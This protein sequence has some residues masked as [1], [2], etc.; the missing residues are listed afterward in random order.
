MGDNRMF[1]W[2][3]SSCEVGC[4]NNVDQLVPRRCFPQDNKT[5]VVLALS[6][7]AGAR[8]VADVLQD[9]TL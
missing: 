3:R 5:P 4:G 8:S 1:G 9:M 6:T 7:A 2:P